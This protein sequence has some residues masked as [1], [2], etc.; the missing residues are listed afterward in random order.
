MGL[1]S[2]ALKDGIEWKKGFVQANLD[3]VKAHE[4][5]NAALIQRYTAELNILNTPNRASY[6]LVRRNLANQVESAR[7]NLAALNGL[8]AHREKLH[9]TAL[10]EELAAA[11]KLLKALEDLLRAL[12]KEGRPAH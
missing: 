5:G 8:A 7:N 3:W 12:E 10:A 9:G 6:D 1:R 11:R 2:V 4:P